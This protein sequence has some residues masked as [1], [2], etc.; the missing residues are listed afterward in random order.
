M[1][2]QELIQHTELDSTVDQIKAFFLG[3]QSAEKPLPFKLA[4]EELLSATPEAI[5]QLQDEL[6]LLW[7]N[8]A[9]NKTQEYAQF[10]SSESSTQSFLAHAKDQL[11]YFL[12]ALS[13]S[14]T[15]VESCDDEDLAD[16]IDELEDTVMELDDY[17]AGPANEAEALELKSAL[18]E[19]W[20]DF[21]QTAKR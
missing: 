8:I 7:D 9:K 2:L 12:T 19:T 6:K 21:I 1:K 5:P 20:Q 15:N 4:L 16:L 10:F 17:L 14:G 11:D 18:E 13:L 3:V